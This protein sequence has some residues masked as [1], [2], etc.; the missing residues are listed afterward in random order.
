MTVIIEMAF[1]WVI[2]IFADVKLGL[3]GYRTKL[4]LAI[5]KPQLHCSSFVHLI[6]GRNLVM[7]VG[8]FVSF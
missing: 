3:S 8:A 2:L 6:P 1:N 7:C 5:K 4:I